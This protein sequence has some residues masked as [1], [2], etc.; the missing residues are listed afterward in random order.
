MLQSHD[1]WALF[2]TTCGQKTYASHI[3]LTS[4]ST[5]QTIEADVGLKRVKQTDPKS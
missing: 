5:G 1:A 2:T 3:K 4:W